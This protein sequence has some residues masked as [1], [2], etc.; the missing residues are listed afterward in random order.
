M[1]RATPI[2][3]V[4]LSVVSLLPCAALARSVEPGA[5]SLALLAG[6][7]F[8]LGRTLGTSPAYGSL[9]IQ[10]EYT[11][12]A[13]SSA[14][15]AVLGSFGRN[16]NL[17]LHLGPRFRLAQRAVPLVPFVQAQVALG[18]LFNVLG[19]DL[20]FIGGRLGAGVEYYLLQDFNISLMAGLDLGSTAGVRPAFYGAVDVLL[21][22]AWN[23]GPG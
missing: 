16:Q 8:S 1:L 21:G 23:F 12:D 9:G 3:A 19:A 18:R 14:V 17:R 13:T 5:T 2:L 11:F 7:S 20:Q 22:A 6:P 10:A 15:I 4:C